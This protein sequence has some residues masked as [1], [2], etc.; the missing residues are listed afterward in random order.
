MPWRCPSCGN[1]I[2][3]DESQSTPRVGTRYRCH[4]CRIGLEYRPD[5]NKMVIV[6]GDD[7]SETK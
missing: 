7:D 5:A 1:V 3:H 6:R 4:L 2:K